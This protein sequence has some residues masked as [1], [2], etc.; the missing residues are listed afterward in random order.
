MIEHNGYTIY[1]IN[2]LGKW[3]A[4][5]EKDGVKVMETSGYE[6]RDTAKAVSLTLADH[7]AEQV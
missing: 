2:P 6:Y 7:Y 4:L 3:F 5:I 1:L